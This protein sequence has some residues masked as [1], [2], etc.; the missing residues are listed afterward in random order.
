MPYQPLY[1]WRRTTLDESDIPTDNDWCGYDGEVCIGRIQKQL[2][3]P[4]RDKWM[5]AGHG[6]HTRKR[7]LPH[8]GYVTEGREAMRAV[9][10]YYHSLMRLNGLKGSKQD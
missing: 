7:F 8:S 4:T 10:E 9:E 1:H 5:W 3:G 2:H 6:P